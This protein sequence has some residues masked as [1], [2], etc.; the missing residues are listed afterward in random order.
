MS[1]SN[2][3]RV[4]AIQWGVTHEDIA[5]EEYCKLGAVV[6]KTGCLQ[7]VV[8]WYYIEY[9]KYVKIF[10]KHFRYIPLNNYHIR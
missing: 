6:S 4:A 3:E 8:V 5:I 2:L 7:F 10:T 1:S 9:M